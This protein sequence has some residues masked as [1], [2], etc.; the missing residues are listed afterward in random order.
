MNLPNELLLQIT[1]HITRSDLKN[2]RLVSKTWSL[3]SSEY[4]FDKIYVST[5]DEDFNI[6]KAIS[7]HP[8]LSKCVR[9]LEYDPV[10][11]DTTLSLSDYVKKLWHQLACVVRRDRSAHHDRFDDS[12]CDVKWLVQ[13]LRMRPTSEVGLM[14]FEREAQSLC[15]GMHFIQE[16]YADWGRRAKREIELKANESFAHNMLEGLRNLTRLQ[17]VRLNNAW[18][19]LDTEL[20]DSA[21]RPKVRYGSPL[22]RQ[23]NI[24]EVFPVNG[25]WGPR[26]IGDGYS[27][28]IA[29]FHNLAWALSHAEKHPRTLKCP[30]IPPTAF[31]L[32]ET[33]KAS[34]TWLSW[35]AVYTNLRRLELNLDFR[36]DE[37]DFWEQRNLENL[38]WLL[39]NVKN[40]QHLRLSLPWDYMN[41]PKRARLFRYDNVFPARVH[42]PKLEFLSVQNLSLHMKD[43]VRLFSCRTTRKLEQLEIGNIELLSGTWESAIEILNS[44]PMDL[45]TFRIYEDSFLWDGSPQRRQFITSKDADDS[46]DDYDPGDDDDLE[47]GVDSDDDDD[48]EHED[49]KMTFVEKIHEYVDYKHYISPLRHPCLNPNCPGDAALGYLRDARETCERTEANPFVLTMLDM[50]IKD[51]TIAYADRKEYLERKG[52][53]DE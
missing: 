22:A 1:S 31:L 27:Q 42:W 28:G 34:R 5:Q 16:G 32:P 2:A 7:Q 41:S 25:F 4:L 6:F 37:P 49:D 44:W 30:D 24:F 9:T 14:A 35:F 26:A 47:D 36:A 3:Y 45:V 19:F 23:W 15:L 46:E 8:V 39:G 33:P 29:D 12:D 20:S 13:M 43:F 52:L 38:Q 18:S 17:S 11:F 50:Y 21:S 40:L 10:T 48:S 51:A 53:A